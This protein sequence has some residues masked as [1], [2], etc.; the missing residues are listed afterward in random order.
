MWHHA[1][2]KA[3]QRTHAHGTHAKP[4]PRYHRHHRRHGRAH[5]TGHHWEAHAGRSHRVVHASH[6]SKAALLLVLFLLVL[7][8]RGGVSIFADSSAAAVFMITVGMLTTSLS[9]LSS[10]RTKS[11]N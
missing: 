5:H 7:A 11:K 3:R 4:K 2:A 9:P 8:L 6:V 10:L 1:H